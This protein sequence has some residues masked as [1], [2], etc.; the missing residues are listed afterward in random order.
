M[1]LIHEEIQDGLRRVIAEG[2]LGSP[3]RQDPNGWISIELLPSTQSVISQV[4]C[5]L[6]VGKVLARDSGFTQKVADFSYSVILWSIIFGWCPPFIRPRI[7]NILPIKKTKEGLS[8]AL[9]RHILDCIDRLQNEQVDEKDRVGKEVRS[10]LVGQKI[11][12]ID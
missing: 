8:R 7:S 2:S 1:P 11:L 5:R 10:S 3:S 4:I 12:I 9:R 6:L